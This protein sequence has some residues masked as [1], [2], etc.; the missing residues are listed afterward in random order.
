MKRAK[1]EA[2]SN[3][4][5]TT[6]KKR[7]ASARAAGQHYREYCVGAHCE[8]VVGDMR[9]PPSMTCVQ[10]CRTMIF[11]KAKA[12]P[13]QEAVPCLGRV[14]YVLSSASSPKPTA[15]LHTAP[16]GNGVNHVQTATKRVPQPRIKKKARTPHRG[17]TATLARRTGTQAHRQTGSH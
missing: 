14:V 4:S 16:T 9:C 11:V 17:K 15:R 13:P 1:T 12:S 10:T 3:P 7:L 8:G 2:D 6:E 5:R